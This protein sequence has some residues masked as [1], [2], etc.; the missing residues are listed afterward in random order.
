[1]DINRNFDLNSCSRGMKKEVKQVD[2]NENQ[3]FF[4]IKFL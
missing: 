1:M 3:S 2:N 4:M